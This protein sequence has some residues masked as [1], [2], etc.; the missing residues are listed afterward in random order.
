M[1]NETRY[2]IAVIAIAALVTWTTRALPFLVFGG[3]PLPKLVTYLGSVLPAA[4]LVI[5]VVYCLRD[6]NFGKAPYGIPAIAACLLIFLV[7]KLTKNMYLSI[8]LGTV[9]YM[10]LIRLL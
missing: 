10:A 1:P 2:V 4:I 9:C 7:Q 6:M 5:L 8:V 3:R